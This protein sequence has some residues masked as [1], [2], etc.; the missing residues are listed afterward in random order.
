MTPAELQAVAQARAIDAIAIATR[1]PAD[2]LHMAWAPGIVAALRAAALRE[3]GSVHKWE[4]RLHTEWTIRG[5]AD[6]WAVVVYRGR[7]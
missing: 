4:V 6:R 3:G 5:N 1:Y 2:S 7:A